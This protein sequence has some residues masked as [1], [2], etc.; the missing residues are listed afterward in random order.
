[1]SITAFYHFF[2]PED[3]SKCLMS[4]MWIDEQLGCVVR[5]NL[6]TYATI[7]MHITMPVNFMYTPDIAMRDRLVKY[8]NLRYPFVNI[9]GIRSLQ[10]ENVYEG[11]TLSELYNHCLTNDGYVLYFHNK[12][13]HS[14]GIETTCWRQI[15]NH[16]MITEWKQCVNALQDYE[17]SCVSDIHVE[18]SEHAITSGNFWW[19]RNTYIRTLQP[20]LSVEDYAPNHVDPSIKRYAYELWLRKNTPSAWYIAHTKAWH[21][22]TPIFLEAMLE[23]IDLPRFH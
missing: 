19:A 23:G 22:D 2:I 10:D 4:S 13:M 1:M 8:I 16:Y 9:I 20:P 18:N 11:S 17:I 12:G 14:T 21:Y 7:N 5:S 15:L 3:I 6:H